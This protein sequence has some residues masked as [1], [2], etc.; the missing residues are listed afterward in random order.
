MFRILILYLIS[1]KVDDGKPLGFFLSTILR[2]DKQ[3]RRFYTD[4]QDLNARLRC[5]TSIFLRQTSKPRHLLPI[6]KICRSVV[7]SSIEKPGRRN[8]GSQFAVLVLSALL[9][10]S[11]AAFLS[12]SVSQESGAVQAAP[13]AD[14]VA[15]P[16]DPTILGELMQLCRTSPNDAG[17]FFQSSLSSSGH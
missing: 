16:N 5:D 11:T 8:V 2:F 4:L 9:L 14:R 3:S 15:M 6:N 17:P 1:Q 12:V 7:F 10:L 13:V